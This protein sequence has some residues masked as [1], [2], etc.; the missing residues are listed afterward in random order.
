MI[1]LCHVDPNY[2][3]AVVQS[4]LCRKTFIEHNQS[5][6]NDKFIIIRK[7][8]EDLKEYYTEYNLDYDYGCYNR[9][10]AIMNYINKNSLFNE[11]IMVLDPD[12]F[13]TRKM[14]VDKI[15]DGEFF[16]TQWTFPDPDIMKNTKRRIAGYHDNSS[17]SFVVPYYA[18]GSVIA[19]LEKLILIYDKITRDVIR[20]SK[21]YTPSELWM[22]EMYT[23]SVVTNLL[24]IESKYTD[25]SSFCMWDHETDYDEISI[26]HYPW[27]MIGTR[28]SINKRDMHLADKMQTNLL[29]C[30]SPKGKYS[31]ILYDFLKKEYLK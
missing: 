10:I 16:G 25:L 5:N 28:S 29:K 4:E 19:E 30:G 15:K 24:K 9:N 21:I 3:S 2:S 8:K 13:F 26:F 18:K 20:N 12:M 31:K 1:Y 11:D 6:Q 14:T 7:S 22:S 17:F 23:Q 27:E